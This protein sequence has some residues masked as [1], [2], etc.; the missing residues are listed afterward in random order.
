MA[1][2]TEPTHNDEQ[3]GTEAPKKRRATR[4]ATRKTAE[5]AAPKV[6][7]HALAKEL[8]T[9][10]KALIEVLAGLGLTKV[11]QS[12][13]TPEEVEQVKAALAPET[14]ETPETPEVDEEKIR[15]R[16]R[17]TPKKPSAAGEVN[18]CQVKRSRNGTIRIKVV[19]SKPVQVTIIQRAR[20]NETYKPW[21]R[22][23]RYK[24][25]P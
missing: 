9:T 10:S 23:I 17:C 14:P 12:T 7:V 18:Y 8:D 11:A 13:L 22:V 5:P 16:V 25:R 21:K 19:G 20:G 15:T 4:R 3:T 6:R 2:S 1:D 24:L